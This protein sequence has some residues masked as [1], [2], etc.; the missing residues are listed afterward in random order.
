MRG[1]MSKL[2]KFLE[3]EG[4]G[5][6]LRDI[7]FEKYL[8]AEDY[9]S[10]T[11]LK[12][13][14][15]AFENSTEWALRSGDKMAARL[16]WFAAYFNAGGTIENPSRAAALEAERIT[17]VMQNMS[18]MS[19]SAPA[20]KYNTV[21]QKLVMGIFFAFKSFA[22]NS[23]LNMWYSGRY[24]L[25]SKEARVV[26]SGQI[27]SILAYHA[28]AVMA[29]RPTYQWIAR[30]AFGGDDD[31][32]EKNVGDLET[33]LTECVWDGLVCMASPQVLNASLRYM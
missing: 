13:V 3:K 1:K 11:K 7:L 26:L 22:I 12:A 29:V 6:Q 19:F 4:L 15:N 10:F 8:S 24:S 2:Q 30:K 32:E 17:G 20:F 23:C 33:I 21:S 25:N 14:G 16:V 9:R 18:D 31:D 5:I 28:L 27:G